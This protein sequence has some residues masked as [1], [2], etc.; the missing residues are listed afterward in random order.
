MNLTAHPE[1]NTRNENEYAVTFTAGDKSQTFYMFGT[2]KGAKTW[3]GREKRF[4]ADGDVDV[5]IHCVHKGGQ[6]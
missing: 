4:F 1:Q 6:A 3:A 2:R 5:K